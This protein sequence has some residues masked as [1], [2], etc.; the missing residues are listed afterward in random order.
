MS[1]VFYGVV[2]MLYPVEEDIEV[3]VFVFSTLHSSL[4]LGLSSETG[5]VVMVVGI[6]MLFCICYA[7]CSTVAL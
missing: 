1:V 6:Q 7:P 3:L 4:C 5:L 2:Q